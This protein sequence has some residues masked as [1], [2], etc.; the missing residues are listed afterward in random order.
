MVRFANPRW[1]SDALCFRMRASTKTA[2]AIS[3]SS[4]PRGRTYTARTRCS[5]SSSFRPERGPWR[6]PP[7]RPQG[8]RAPSN[9][10]SLKAILRLVVVGVGSSWIATAYPSRNRRWLVADPMSPT[11]RT[12]TTRPTSSAAARENHLHARDGKHTANSRRKFTSANLRTPISAPI[13]PAHDGRH[14][15]RQ[16]GGRQRLH[17]GDMARQPGNGVQ[18]DEG[19]RRARRL[20]E[21]GPA[22]EQ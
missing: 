5:A 22:H 10:A 21:A 8:S 13:I 1:T 16:S 7:P 15:P 3:F 12:R 11:P 17:A 14:G 20:L 6:A 18:Q 19:R 4:G 2:G 9:T